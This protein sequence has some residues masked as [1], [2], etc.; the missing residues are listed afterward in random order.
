DGPLVLLKGP[1]VAQR[2]PTRARRFG[3]LDLLPEDAEAAQAALL[4][5]GFRLEDR[6]WP[7]PGY[8]DRRRPHYHLHPL[9]WPGLALRVEVHRRVKWP[10]GFEAPRN[11][12][13]FDAA[14][15]SS[16]MIDGLLVPHPRHQAVL[17]ASHAWGEVAMRHL[18]ELFDVAVFVDDAERDELA[19]VAEHWGFRRGWET[20]L[21]VADWLLRH[22]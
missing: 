4:A 6:D 19:R 13:L 10:K 14:V 15:P 1:E 20:T 8:D 9:E 2:Y 12:D 11:E 7:P 17:L 18:R 3:D 16:L 22:G 21:A 5:A